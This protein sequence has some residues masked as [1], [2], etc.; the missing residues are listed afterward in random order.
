MFVSRRCERG[1]KGA[2]TRSH[3]QLV[4]SG[5]VILDDPILIGSPKPFGQINPFSCVHVSTAEAGDTNDLAVVN[6]SVIDINSEGRVE[7][8]GR[9]APY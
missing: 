1:R 6:A 7:I 5:S 2:G 4:D 8:R 3:V 9:R